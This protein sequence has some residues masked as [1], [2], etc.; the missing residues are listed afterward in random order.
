[1]VL[2]Q[3]SYKDLEVLVDTDPVRYGLERSRITFYTSL[4]P[5]IEDLR[6]L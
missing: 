4:E 3:T 5:L 6:K 1:M 2:A